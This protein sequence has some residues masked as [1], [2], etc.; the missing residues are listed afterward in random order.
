M[1]NSVF[2][3][4]M[5]PS[6]IIPWSALVVTTAFTSVMNRDLHW[7]LLTELLRSIPLKNGW[8]E[9]IRF[10]LRKR[11]ANSIRC[12]WVNDEEQEKRYKYGNH[13]CIRIH[14]SFHS[15]R[16]NTHCNLYLLFF[17]RRTA[18]RSTDRPAE[19]SSVS[20]LW[21]LLS[22][23]RTYWW[24]QSWL[25]MQSL[26]RLWS[27]TACRLPSYCSAHSF[28]SSCFVPMTTWSMV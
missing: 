22:V 13:N 14:F 12:Y 7:N 27:K 19:S 24:G 25:L 16:S 6:A 10:I 28:W 20:V 3:F 8:K 9:S 5:A 4:R 15:S 2:N 21:I 17:V 11:T 23:L 1:K 26:P 18:Y